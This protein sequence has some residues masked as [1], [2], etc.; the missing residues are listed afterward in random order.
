MVKI[1]KVVSAVLVLGIAAGLLCSHF[2]FNDQR[3][4]GQALTKLQQEISQPYN[5]DRLELA[6]LGTA[7]KKYFISG[8]QIDIQ[9]PSYGVLQLDG[10]DEVIQVCMALRQNHPE[11]KISFANQQLTILK[12]GQAALMALTMI[13]ERANEPIN[14]QDLIVLLAKNEDGNWQII[15]IVHAPAEKNE[16]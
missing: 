10:R 3:Q 8:V 16:S 11:A 9:N 7:L 13:V 12:R 2:I 5:G 4:I 6:K 15:K 14:P 1:I